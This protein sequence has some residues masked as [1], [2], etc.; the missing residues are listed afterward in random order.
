M[1]A[2]RLRSSLSFSIVLHLALLAGWM[3]VLGK[4]TATK[5][6]DLSSG[7][8]V[9]VPVDIIE[10]PK[11]PDT[12]RNR[13]VQTESRQSD[14]KARPDAFLGEKN[15]TV[16]R[17]T[18]SRSQM[19][20][21]GRGSTKVAEPSRPSQ[22]RPNPQAPAKGPGRSILSN[23]GVPVFS[24]P[25]Q[26]QEAL[27]QENRAKRPNW[28]SAGAENEVPSDYIQGISEGDRTALNTR[29]Y[30]FFGYF[31]RIRSRLDVAWSSTLR[32]RLEKLYRKGRR[33]A[34]DKEFKTRT[35]VVL[36]EKGSVV[37]VRLMEES[38][39]YDLDDAAIAAFNEAGPF[40]NPPKGLINERGQVEVHWDFVLRN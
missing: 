16:D 6:S 3:I 23:L 36:D 8:R 35:W 37:K 39:V 25:R 11:S 9:P 7:G 30:M 18:V 14:S 17:E 20:K 13:M 28:A 27:T 12:T 10:V 1:G 34:S 21:A 24:L 4:R 29:E 19:V 22:A 38:G 33:I 32:Q 15:Q 40:P 2:S 31:Q 5:W 26:G